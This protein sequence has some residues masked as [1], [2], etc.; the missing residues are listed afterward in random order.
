MTAA[1]HALH[2]I[3]KIRASR[4]SLDAATLRVPEIRHQGTDRRANP[5]PTPTKEA[6]II[7]TSISVFRLLQKMLLDWGAVKRQSATCRGL[8]FDVVR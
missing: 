8:S 5:A 6:T 3:P 2:R 1:P 7:V 4:K